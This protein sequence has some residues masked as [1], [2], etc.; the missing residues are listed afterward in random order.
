VVEFMKLVQAYEETLSLI[1]K[2]L[3]PSKTSSHHARLE[4]T[5]KRIEKAIRRKDESEWQRVAPKN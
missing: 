1:P 4:R 2:L 3:Y 5:I